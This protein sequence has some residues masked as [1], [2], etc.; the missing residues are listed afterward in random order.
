MTTHLAYL[1]ALGAA[2]C[3]ACSGMIAITPVRQAGSFAFNYARM[4]LVFAMLLAALAV[5]RGWPSLT[6]EQWL[7]LT[8]SGLIGILVGDTI[9]YTSLG[10]LGPRRNS[11]IFATNAPMTAV[12]GY[13]WLGEALGWQAVAGVALVTAG[14]AMAI[15]FGGRREDAH[16][17]ESVRGDV[18]VGVAIGLTAALC[19]SIGTLIAKPV[20]AAGVDPV[21]ASAV[22][23]GVSALGLTIVAARRG[24]AVFS[25]FTPGTLALTAASGF[26]GV[27]LGMTLLLYGMGHGNTG[28]IATLSATTPVMVLPLLWMRTRQR[29]A[30]GAWW[31]ALI[32]SAGVAL[33]FNR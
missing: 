1:A 15:A 4:L 32:A 17:W 7:R 10:R 25:A 26:V 11:I 5:L 28:V 21:G 24:R 23:V 27:A 20:M 33:I 6:L 9:L 31:G 19:H 29:P 30:P 18:R 13:C 8:A 16:H 14:V 12:L 2:L 22:R 3:W